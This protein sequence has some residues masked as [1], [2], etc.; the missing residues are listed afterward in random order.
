MRV[1]LFRHTTLIAAI[2]Y[3]LLTLANPT[4]SEFKHQSGTTPPPPRTSTRA[5]DGWKE[6]RS[7]ELLIQMRYPSH[8]RDWDI[9]A[10]PLQ[11]E[12]PRYRSDVD[13]WRAGPG[14][15]WALTSVLEGGNDQLIIVTRKK[16][17]KK[18]PLR[19]AWEMGGLADPTRTPELVTIASSTALRLRSVRVEE[20]DGQAKYL[21]TDLVLAQSE[22]YLYLFEALTQT[23]DKLEGTRR[24]DEWMEA[25]S[26]VRFLPGGSDGT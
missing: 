4:A 12:A 26:T 14:S 8:W 1:Y 20:V 6:L 23:G 10:F 22:Q 9:A 11:D 19:E 18:M 24:S 17:P 25:V 13:F 15:A 2:A 5:S 16:L 7:S 3:I 21:Y